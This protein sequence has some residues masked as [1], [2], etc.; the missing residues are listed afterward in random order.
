MASK[1]L[2]AMLYLAAAIFGFIAIMWV[3]FYFESKNP[4]EDEWK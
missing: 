2:H 4:S 1:L 3:L